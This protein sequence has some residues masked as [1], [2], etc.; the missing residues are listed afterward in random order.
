MRV[1]YLSLL[2]LFVVLWLDGEELVWPVSVSG[3]P[4]SRERKKLVGE[5]DDFGIV[6]EE[7]L[8]SSVVGQRSPN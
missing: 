3:I 7:A 6:E 1:P 4:T 8:A 5:D 2:S